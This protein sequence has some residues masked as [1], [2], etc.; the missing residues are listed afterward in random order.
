MA[1]FF[2]TASALSATFGHA[3]PYKAQPSTPKRSPLQARAGLYSAWSVAE[4]TKQKA[5]QLSDAAAKEV[6]KASAAA[7]A[8]TGQIELY[9]A[10]YYAACTFGG[11]LACGVTHWGVTPLDLVKCRRQVD[12]KL[13]KGNF[14]GWRKIVAAD[15]MKG[16]YTGGGATFMG[17]SVQGAA[18]YGIYEYFKKTYS[19]LAGEENAVRYKTWIYLAGSA[20]AEFFADIGLC[21]FEAVKVRTQTTLPPFAKGPFDG[22]SKIIA[23]EGVGGY[24][25][26]SRPTIRSQ[27]DVPV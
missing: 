1:S 10:K 14:D 3:T 16:I 25:L 13:Y 19:D 24:A 8:Q 17:Y 21:P 6:G 12:A 9:S 20:S 22:F 2:P 23:A 18:K 26:R 5:V 27:A 11:M 15:G 4:D 7:R